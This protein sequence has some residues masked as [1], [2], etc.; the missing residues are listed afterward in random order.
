VLC[1]ERFNKNI[2]QVILSIRINWKHLAQFQKLKI[3]EDF[4]DGAGV[5]KWK[6]MEIDDFTNQLPEVSP[7][8]EFSIHTSLVQCI[9]S[10]DMSDGFNDMNIEDLLEWC[11]SPSS[12]SE[13][14]DKDYNFMVMML[15]KLLPHI[16]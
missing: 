4:D 11:P 1:K 9:C 2:Y 10:D 5:A 13:H 3:R 8:N 7:T 12:E 16:E 15:E 14:G 6:E